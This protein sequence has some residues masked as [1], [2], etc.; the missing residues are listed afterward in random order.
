MDDIYKDIEEYSTG[1][2]CKVFRVFHDMIVDIF[3]KKKPNPLATELFI[4]GRKLNFSF[5]FITPSYFPV[6][7]NIRLRST[8]I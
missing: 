4:R 3:S 6:P 5:V 2:E 8:H 1:K 7:K